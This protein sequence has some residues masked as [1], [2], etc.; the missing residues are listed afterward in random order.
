MYFNQ[1]EFGNRLRNLRKERGLTQEQ[2][3]TAV[4]VSLVHLG[5]IELGKRGISVDLVIEL[6]IFLDISLDFLVLGTEHTSGQVHQ[7]IAQALEIL[8]ELDSLTRK[9]S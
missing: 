6:S 9:P 2:L 8:N 3:A 7:K 4:N 5:N 1:V